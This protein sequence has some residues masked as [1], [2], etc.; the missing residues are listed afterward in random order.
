V[1]GSLFWFLGAVSGALA[2]ALFWVFA[3]RTGDRMLARATAVAVIVC[4]GAAFIL[5][6]ML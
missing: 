6:R 5:G 3:V 2:S 1:S 4:C